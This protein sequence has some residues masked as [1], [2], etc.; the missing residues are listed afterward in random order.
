MCKKLILT[1]LILLNYSFNVSSESVNIALKVDDEI[2]TTTDI[3][4]ERKYLIALNNDLTK[5]SEKEIIKIA[6]NSI[7][8]EK[9]KIKEL[10]NF[11]DIEN[12]TDENF[13]KP[14]I[15]NFYTRLNIQSLK[16]FENYLIENDLSFRE[17]QQKLKIEVLWNQLIS[18]LYSKQVNVDEKKIRQKIIDEKLNQKDTLEY[19]LSEIVFS[20]ENENLYESTYLKIQESINQ[21]GFKI[22]ANK[23]SIAD[24]GKFGGEIGNINENQLSNLIK[25]I[26]KDTEVGKIT[27]P[28][29][30][31]NG[32]LILRVN[33]KNLIKKS[34]DENKILKELIDFERKKQFDQFSAIHYN[35]SKINSKIQFNE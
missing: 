34:I 22:T 31:A 17:I 13:L 25:G 26:L 10:N 12:I 29:L 33:E 15:K 3:K 35:K 11:I 20:L 19:N 5:L 7:I 16:E 21:L 23:F 27:K 6:Q 8:R 9:I 1:I 30:V 24:S 14:I 4:N 2:I 32:Y 28:I 18:E